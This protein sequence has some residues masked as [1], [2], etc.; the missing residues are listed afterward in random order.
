MAFQSL[1]RFVDP[2]LLKLSISASNSDPASSQAQISIRHPGRIRVPRATN[3]D[4]VSPRDLRVVYPWKLLSYH[5]YLV[6]SKA[7]S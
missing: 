3:L 5:R 6:P 1:L 7:I 4:L 2:H